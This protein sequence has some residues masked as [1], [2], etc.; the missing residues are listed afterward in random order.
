MQTLRNLGEHEVIE[1]LLGQLGTHRDMAVGA[2]D[3]CAVCRLQDTGT[4]QVLTTDPVIENVHFRRS[5][6]PKRI[7]N[8]AAGRVLSDIAA[9]GAQPQWLLVNVVAPDDL[10]FCILQGIYDGMN[11]LCKRF[12]A[13][14]VGGDLSAGPA[15]ELHVF[16]T[17][18]L[19]SG[20]ALLRSGARPGDML[21]T[22]GAI[23]NSHWM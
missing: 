8:K 9:M 2:G 20:S 16:G 13:A 21:F 11:H 15:L 18:I 14:I 10:A 1:R 22:T 6:D 17:G 5:D 3:D 12:G 7:G 19:P 23:L 4:D